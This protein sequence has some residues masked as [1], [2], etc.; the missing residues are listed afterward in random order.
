MEELGSR[1]KLRDGE[2]LVGEQGN[3]EE[4]GEQRT[5]DR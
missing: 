3:K 4:M 2:E 5:P 1:E